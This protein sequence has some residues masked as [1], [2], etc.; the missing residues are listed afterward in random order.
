MTDA[1]TVD[2]E[3]SL[4]DQSISA[5]SAFLARFR[6]IP[7]FIVEKPCHLSYIANSMFKQ[8]AGPIML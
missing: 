6:T 5:L 8:V 3:E 4:S 7:K 2:Q 1:A